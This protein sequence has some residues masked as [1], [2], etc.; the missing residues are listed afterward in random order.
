M[1]VAS[2]ARMKRSVIRENEAAN[3]PHSASLHAGYLS[4]ILSSSHKKTEWLTPPGLFISKPNHSSKTDISQV[5]RARLFAPDLLGYFWLCMT[6][7][8]KGLQ[9]HSKL[10]F[11]RFFN[12]QQILP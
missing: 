6:E 9:L 8:W 2:V 1:V 3:F 4:A 11:D 7:R 12:R 10:D 5:G